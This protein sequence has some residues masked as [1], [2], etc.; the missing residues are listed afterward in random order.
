MEISWSSKIIL[1]KDIISKCKIF[2]ARLPKVSRYFCFDD[3]LRR[4]DENPQA[5]AVLLEVS[6]PLDWTGFGFGVAH[7]GTTLVDCE[8]DDSARDGASAAECNAG[9]HHH[10]AVW[11]TNHFS[12]RHASLKMFHRR[13]QHDLPRRPSHHVKET[14]KVVLVHRYILSCHV[15]PSFRCDR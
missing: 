2:I 1:L 12:D 5:K 11:W 14:I 9:D 15:F 8:V 7:D 13:G 6:P 3:W 10:H 4:G